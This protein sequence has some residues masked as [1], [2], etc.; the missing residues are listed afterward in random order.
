MWK[1]P[2]VAGAVLLLLVACGGGDENESSKSDD[3]TTTQVKD[4]D[5]TKVGGQQ[6]IYQDPV[7]KKYVTEYQVWATYT[8]KGVEYHFQSKKTLDRF[9]QNP[10]QYIEEDESEQ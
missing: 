4:D 8:Y 9:K 3:Q 7:S 10:E 2:F 6:R 5:L 1:R